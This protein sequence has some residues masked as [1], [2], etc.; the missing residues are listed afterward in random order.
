MGVRTPSLYN[1]TSTPL[2]AES[3]LG[4]VTSGFVCCC[5]PC[6]PKCFRHLSAQIKTSLSSSS[7]NPTL[8]LQGGDV[9]ARRR[10]PYVELERPNPA[11]TYLK[12][13]RIVLNE[14]EVDAEAQKDGLCSRGSIWKTV[15]VEVTEERP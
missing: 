6:L 9:L 14:Y 3:R 5:L 2:T 10:E 1:L 12:Q 15:T 4:E 7:S 11:E 13:S 8:G